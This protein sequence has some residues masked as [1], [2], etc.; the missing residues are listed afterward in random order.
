RN[1]QTL[2]T[3][4]AGAGDTDGDDE[5]PDWDALRAKLSE[6]TGFTPKAPINVIPAQQGDV[7]DNEERVEYWEGEFGPGMVLVANPRY[8]LQDETP[9]R[10]ILSKFGFEGYVPPQFPGD[11]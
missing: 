11:K 3:I 7:A 2:I 10:D 4:K 6:M 8:Y 1:C 9:D 5:E